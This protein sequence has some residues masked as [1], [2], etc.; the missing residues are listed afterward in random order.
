ML[1]FYLRCLQQPQRY[2]AHFDLD[3]FF[4]SVEMIN[5]PSLKGK[6]VLVGGSRERGVV[7]AC[8]YEA[9]KFGI[10]SAMPMATAMKLCP[11]AIVV[12]GARGEYSRYSRW[13]TEIIAAKAP[14]FEKASIDEFYIDLT[15]M[16]RYFDPFAWTK[17]LRQEIIAATQLP[18]S[19]ALASNKFVAKVA[20]DQAKPNG[21]IFIRPGK[22]KDFLSPL[23]VEKIPGVGDS[24]FQVLKAMGIS[25]IGDILKFTQADLEEQLGK[26]GTELWQKA[27]GIHHGEVHEYHEAKSVSTENTFHQNTADTDF[28]ITQLVRMTEKVAYELR[29]DEKLAGCVAVKIRYSDFETTSKQAAIDYTF[30]DDELITVAKDL[31]GK[32]YRKGQQVRLIGVRLSELTSHGRQVSLF[33]DAEKQNNLYKAIDSVKNRYGR[34]ALLKARTAKKQDD[35]EE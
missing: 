6:P 3:S 19:F 23:P 27:Q 1:K 31:F 33:E 22:E 21:Y 11:Q 8:S 34:D 24:T 15:G 30:R 20:T 16:D 4:V 12:R 28:L 13:V 32:L 2:I 35:E 5:D 7:A 18:I 26:W 14:K 25:R 10:H 29:Q 17:E 9:R